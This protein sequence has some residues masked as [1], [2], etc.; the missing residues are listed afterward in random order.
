MSPPSARRRSTSASA[1]T[2]RASLTTSTRQCGRRARENAPS[3]TSSRSMLALAAR[4]RRR[5]RR[6]RSPASSAVGG[7]RSATRTGPNSRVGSASSGPLAARRPSTPAWAAG[8]CR[9]TSAVP[10][11]THTQ[12]RYACEAAALAAA[13]TLRRRAGGAPRTHAD[14]RAAVGTA[15]A[16][17]SAGV[18]GG[19]RQRGRAD[20]GAQFLGRRRGVTVAAARPRHEPARHAAHRRTLLRRSARA[21][22]HARRRSAAARHHRTRWVGRRRPWRHLRC[23]RRS[24][25]REPPRRDARRRRRVRPARYHTPSVGGYRRNASERVAS[26]RV[27]FVLYDSNLALADAARRRYVLLLFHDPFHP[28]ANRAP[29]TIVAGGGTVLLPHAPTPT[30]VVKFVARVRRRRLPS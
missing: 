18:A 29:I 3:M 30:E 10:T 13:R 17:T 19:W 23:A 28:A 6:W 4:R 26:Q 14:A 7:R 27:A 2:P 16:C 24:L 1:L 12:A 25:A 9:R 11:R 21:R 8:G 22:R 5:A 15:A 20:G